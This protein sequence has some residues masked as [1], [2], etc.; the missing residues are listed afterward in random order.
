M[1]QPNAPG[2]RQCEQMDKYKQ[3]MFDLGQ[4]SN[5]C[6]EVTKKIRGL[7]KIQ[8]GYLIL[9]IFVSIKNICYIPNCHIVFLYS[10]LLAALITILYSFF[11]EEETRNLRR[12]L[13]DK[14]PVVE[15]KLLR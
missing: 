10:T 11:L 14:R 1:G 13:Y 3:N 8:L 15:N 5:Y 7:L 12:Q 6:E 4:G 9:V 2:V